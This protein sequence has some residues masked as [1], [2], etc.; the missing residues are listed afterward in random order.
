[1]LL[2]LAVTVSLLQ[3]MAEAA[4]PRLQRRP[5]QPQCVCEQEKW[6]RGSSASLSDNFIG[7]VAGNHSSVHITLGNGGC[8]VVDIE[9][10]FRV[11]LEPY[12]P[13][14]EPTP[15]GTT[16]VTIRENQVPRYQMETGGERSHESMKWKLVYSHSADGKPKFGSLRANM[17]KQAFIPAEHLFVSDTIVSMSNTSHISMNNNTEQELV[18]QNDAYHWFVTV[19]TTGRRFTQLP[20]RCMQ[21]LWMC[22]GPRSPGYS[23]DDTK[24]KVTTE[25]L[26]LPSRRTHSDNSWGHEGTTN[27]T[28]TNQYMDLSVVD[29]SIVFNDSAV[30]LGG[31]VTSDGIVDS[32]NHDNSITYDAPTDTFWMTSKS[33]L[34]SKDSWFTILSLPIKVEFVHIPGSHTCR[35]DEPPFISVCMYETANRCWRV[36]LTLLWNRPVLM[37]RVSRVTKCSR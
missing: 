2:A 36:C 17:G 11:V 14:S 6:W 30:P 20:N 26:Y 15:P 9:P 23:T 8:I 13:V 5:P 7:W 37:P 35:L 31:L 21:G 34:P 18:F 27:E 1:M 16:G 33:E 19:N 4:P 24:L 22:K 25:T 3:K 28:S 29:S 12:T 10:I 32:T